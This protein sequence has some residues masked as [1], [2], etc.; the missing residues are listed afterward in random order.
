MKLFTS[1][2]RVDYVRIMVLQKARKQDVQE[3]EASRYKVLAFQTGTST[4]AVAG[5][6]ANFCKQK[7]IL[8][9]NLLKHLIKTTLK[10]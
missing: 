2:P 8:N 5:F 9:E 10:M 4:F 6:C 7:I 3:I 1:S